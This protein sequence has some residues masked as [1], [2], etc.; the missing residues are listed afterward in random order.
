[1]VLPEASA[2][3]R[4]GLASLHRRGLLKRRASANLPATEA[5]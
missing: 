1:M 5:L 3:V 4:G 2:F